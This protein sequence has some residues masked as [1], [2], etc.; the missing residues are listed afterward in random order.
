MEA[1]M[2]MLN[3]KETIRKTENYWWGISVGNWQKKFPRKAE[4][5]DF[6]YQNSERGFIVT[7]LSNLYKPSRIKHRK[8]VWMPSITK[9]EMWAELYLHIQHMKE[10]YPRSTGRLCRYCHEPWTYLVRKKQ[11]GPKKPNIRGTQLSTNFAIDRFNSK[12]TYI[13]GNII[14]CCSECND[15]KHD[16]RLSDWKNF[17]RVAHDLE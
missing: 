16:S 4:R 6:K 8:K 11:R 3:N 9:E 2:K 5:A 15:R 14:F 12:Q 1:E 13:K 7:Y 17:L 10:L